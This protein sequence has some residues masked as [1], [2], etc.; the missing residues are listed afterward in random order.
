ML[1]IKVKVSLIIYLIDVRYF[2]VWEIE[3]L[4]F[5]LFF[6]EEFSVDVC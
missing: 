5:Y 2:V 4:G 3:W 6:G 1:S